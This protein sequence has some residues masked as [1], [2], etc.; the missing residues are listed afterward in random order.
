MFLEVL[1][2][3]YDY[4]EYIR[5]IVTGELNNRYLNEFRDFLETYFS[6]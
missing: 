3:D 4:F 1:R 5:Q 2:M 6:E